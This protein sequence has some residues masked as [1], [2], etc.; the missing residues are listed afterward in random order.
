MTSGFWI[1]IE[2]QKALKILSEVIFTLDYCT[3]SEY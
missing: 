2:K 3:Q 1:H